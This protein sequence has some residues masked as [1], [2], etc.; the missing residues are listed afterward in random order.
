MDGDARAGAALSIR[1]SPEAIKFT[2]RVKSWTRWRC[3][4]YP[5]GWLPASWDG[6]HALAIEK[7]EATFDV[8]GGGPGKED[9]QGWIHPR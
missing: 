9:T 6:R 7:A 1:A 4:H 5:N 2:A 8:E 3:F